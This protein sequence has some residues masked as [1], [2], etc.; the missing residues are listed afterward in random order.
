MSARLDDLHA[1]CAD[2]REYDQRPR[3]TRA[4]EALH[5]ATSG[6]RPMGQVLEHYLHPV[7]AFLI[8]PLF[9]FFNAGV[10]AADHR[11][12]ADSPSR[13]RHRA[14]PGA[15]KT[16]RYPCCSAGLPVKSGRAGAAR[17]RH[18]GP[19]SMPPPV[20]GRRRVHRCRSFVTDLA[21]DD[22]EPD[23]RERKSRFSPRRFVAAVWGAGCAASETAEARGARMRTRSLTGR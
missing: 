4:L 7:V 11:S 21:F 16:D 12:G 6:M 18:V 13:T 2:P 3:T 10:V 14:G 20:P 1:R 8:L 15:R 9:A 17:W 22:G 5:R 19:R 23:H